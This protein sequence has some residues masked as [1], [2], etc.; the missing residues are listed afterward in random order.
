MGPDIG[1]KCAQVYA[2][3]HNNAIA[4]SDMAFTE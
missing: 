3:V 4:L 1:I 2:V